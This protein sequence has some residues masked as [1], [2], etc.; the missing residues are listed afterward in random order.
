MPARS[1]QCSAA[2]TPMLATDSSRS[3]ITP[4]FD[5]RNVEDPA[6]FAIQSRGQF[7][8]GDD[9]RR[10]IGSEAPDRRHGLH[11]ALDVALNESDGFEFARMQIG[12]GDLDP[13]LALQFDYQIRA[14]QMNRGNRSRRA[15][16]PDQEARFGL[17]NFRRIP[18]MRSR[19]S[20]FIDYD[21]LRREW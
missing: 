2:L 16:R 8:V 20:I 14:A 15:T 4:L 5:S 10:Q 12:L 7:G 18:R 1:R 19:L 9:A 6:R 11:P 13:E 17:E 3:R 21:F